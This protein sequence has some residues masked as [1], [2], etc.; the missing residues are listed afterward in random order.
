[1]NQGCHGPLKTWKVRELDSRNV[2]PGK[3]WKA[4]KGWCFLG[5]VMESCEIFNV[6]YIFKL[7]LWE[8]ENSLIALLPVCCDFGDKRK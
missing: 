4:W 1:M 7:S 6:G 8:M 3:P 5:K 2:R